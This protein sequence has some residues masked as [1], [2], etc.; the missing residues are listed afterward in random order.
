MG[1]VFIVIRLF[2]SLV[3]KI[4]LAIKTASFFGFF[5]KLKGAGAI[6][7][8]KQWILER[9]NMG[10]RILGISIRFKSSQLITGASNLPQLVKTN[11]DATLSVHVFSSQ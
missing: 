3:T 1:L 11:G 9:K 2:S 7:A 4:L 10:G 6:P 8:L 5:L